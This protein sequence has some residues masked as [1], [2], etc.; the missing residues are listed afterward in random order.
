YTAKQVGGPSF[1]FQASSLQATLKNI[2]EYIRIYHAI[3]KQMTFII[4]DILQYSKIYREAG[5]R[6]F[7]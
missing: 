2:E 5:R 7:L 4:T 3:H 1:E 6:P